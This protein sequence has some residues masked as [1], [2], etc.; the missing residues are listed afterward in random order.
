MWHKFTRY[1]VVF[2]CRANGIVNPGEILDLSALSVTLK[3][4]SQ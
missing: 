4:Q 2:A 3:E 1:G